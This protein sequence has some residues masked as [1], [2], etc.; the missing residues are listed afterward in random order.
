MAYQMPPQSLT[1]H[2]GYLP[3]PF[4]DAILPEV[5]NPGVHRL[6]YRRRIDCLGDRYQ[7]YVVGLPA[8]AASGPLDALS[9]SREPVS[10]FFNHPLK[11][12]QRRDEWRKGRGSREAPKRQRPQARKR[13]E[14]VGMA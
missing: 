3:G 2:L 8:R 4:L 12:Y 7:G 10:N 13:N 9:Y 1:L 14:L 5:P 11:S 6:L